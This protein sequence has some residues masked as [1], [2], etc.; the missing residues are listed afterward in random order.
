[1]LPHSCISHLS[2]KASNYLL[3]LRQHPETKQVHQGATAR[4]V[5]LR[6]HAATPLKSLRT[7]DAFRHKK[8]VVAFPAKVDL[9]SISIT[10]PSIYQF[11]LAF[12]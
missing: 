1:M 11:N 2:L 10:F 4:P 8:A 6:A 7:E 12:V 3:S 9:R 5:V